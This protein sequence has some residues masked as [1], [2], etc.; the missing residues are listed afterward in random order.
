MTETQT[1]N[2]KG[3]VH[4]IYYGKLQEKAYGNKSYTQKEI[5]KELG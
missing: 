3:T 5:L 2:K 4:I 1:L